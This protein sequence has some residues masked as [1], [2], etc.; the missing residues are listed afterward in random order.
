MEQNKSSRS[1]IW[2]IKAIAVGAAA[3]ILTAAA[4]L[5][6]FAFAAL[7]VGKYSSVAFAAPVCVMILGGFAAGLAAAAG[8]RKNPLPN[9]ICSAA[10]TAVAVCIAASGVPGEGGSLIPALTS[11]VGGATGATVGV[12]FRKNR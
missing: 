9:G 4:A 2:R 11:L 10:L 5:A 3:G 7:A 6:A 8:S 12:R 1:Q